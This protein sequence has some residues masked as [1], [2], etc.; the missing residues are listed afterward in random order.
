MKRSSMTV[1]G[2]C[3]LS[4]IA[5][6]QAPADG[7]PAATSRTTTAAPKPAMVASPPSSHPCRA[8]TPAEITTTAARWLGDCPNGIADG[9]GVMRSGAGEPYEFFAGRMR[10]GRLVDG[11][12]VLK[13]GLMMVA[14][15]FDANRRVVVSDGLRPSEDEAVFRTA[16]AGAEA[17]AKRMA[18]AGNKGSAA[19]YTA[20]AKRIREAP[21]E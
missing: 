1:G 17:V 21:P 14:V 5:A 18:S 19:Y 20:L 2:A 6:C 3:L 9:L 10:A 7:A 15:R 11:V 16:T 12:L 4:L 8:Q 13:S